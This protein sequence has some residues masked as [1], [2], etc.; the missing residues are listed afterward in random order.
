MKNIYKMRK[1]SFLN[2]MLM[3]LLIAMV[4]GCKKTFDLEP[5]DQLDVT[6]AYQNVYDADAA[7]VG[8]YGKFIRLADR[9]IILNELR[10]DLLDFTNNADESLRQVS[11]HTVTPDNPYA[12]PRPFYELIINCND[13]LKHFQIM[14]AEKRLNESEFKQRYSDIGALRSFLYLQLGI[15][16]GEVPYVTSPIE[17]VDDVKNASL[18]PKLKFRS[19]H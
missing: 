9:Y 11:T 8:I 15:H 6:N 18:F 12:N 7:I 14:Y 19:S 16:F 3:G 13:V 5:Q 10:G 4:A 2:L 1:L 17:N